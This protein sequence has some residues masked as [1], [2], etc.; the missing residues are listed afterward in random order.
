MTCPACLAN[1]NHGERGCDVHVSCDDLTCEALKDP[2]A[3]GELAD[4]LTHWQGHSYLS[5]CSH[6]C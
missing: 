6:G 2:K 3:Y 4:A 5:G 1:A